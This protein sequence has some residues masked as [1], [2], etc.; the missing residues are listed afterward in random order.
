M[1]ELGATYHT[2]ADLQ[3]RLGPTNELAPVVGLLSQNNE[4]LDDMLWKEANNVIGEQTTVQTGIPTGTWRAYYGGVPNEK[5]T[6]A[7]VTERTGMLSAY[8]TVDAALARA[9][10]NLGQYLFNERQAFFQGMSQTVAAAMIYSSPL[11]TPN[12]IR[13]LA[14]RYSTISGAASGENIID[15]GGTGSTNTSIWL[16][17]F[18]PAHTFGIYPRG[19]QGGLQHRDQGERPVDAP[20]GNGQMQAYVSYFEW[21]CGLAVRDWRYVARAANIDM[22]QALTGNAPNIAN[23]MIRMYHRFPTAPSGIGP[24]QM[25]DDPNEPA[26]PRSAF[27]CNRA[28]RTLMHLQARS[29]KNTQ[30]SLDNY[31]G[32]P[33]MNFLG[34]PVRNVDAILSTEDRVV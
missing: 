34:V 24:V 11:E 31:A 15:C 26:K 10:G 13:G 22:S 23:A 30:L 18:S 17:G 8:S 4:M 14:P 32:K 5:A 1:A 27:Y 21:G 12:K 3:K 20:D 7:Q 9:S 28:V 2:F 6:V 16:V 19:T 33:V 29:D 25:S